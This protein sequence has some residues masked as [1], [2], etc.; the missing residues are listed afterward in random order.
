MGAGIEIHESRIEVSDCIICDNWSNIGDAFA[1]YLTRVTGA[2]RNSIISGN[3]CT[4]AYIYSSGQ[5]LIIENCEI[6]RNGYESCIEYSGIGISGN[7]TIRN[8]TI[9]ENEF[10]GLNTSGDNITVERCLIFD[11]GGYGSVHCYGCNALFLNCTISRY[12]NCGIYCQHGA[13]PTLRNTIVWNG[14]DG[15]ETVTGREY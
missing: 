5:R 10:T 15:W 9:T 7:I 14:Y 13:I 4:G 8:C 1:A 11:N 12:E 6:D 2:I 3:P